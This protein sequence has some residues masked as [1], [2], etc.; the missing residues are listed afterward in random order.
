MENRWSDAEARTFVKRY[1]ERGVNE[2]DLQKFI[3]GFESAR[4]FGMQSVAGKVSSLAHAEI[5][6]GEEDV[7]QVQQANL[8]SLLFYKLNSSELPN[9]ASGASG[10]L[11]TCETEAEKGFLP[12]YAILYHFHLG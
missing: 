6:S 2:D 9:I 3:A 11:N 7:G 10:G 8:N 4:I 12:N 5:Y 1:A